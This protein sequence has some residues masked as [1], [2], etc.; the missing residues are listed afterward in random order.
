MQ[1]LKIFSNK[2]EVKTVDSV[3]SA[4][5]QQIADLENISAEQLTQATS[6]RQLAE[7]SLQRAAQ[8]EQEAVRAS[9]VANK[10]RNLIQ[11]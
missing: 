7:S 1:L 11:L 9:T 2:A 6:A 3:L 10:I 4:F 8:S 5:N